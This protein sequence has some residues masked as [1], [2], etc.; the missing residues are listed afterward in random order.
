MVT[1]FGKRPVTV[2]GCLQA[3]CETHWHCDDVYVIKQTLWRVGVKTR[4]L[5]RPV[6]NIEVDTEAWCELG[7][8]ALSGCNNVYGT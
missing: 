5:M 6:S 1:A 2:W 8:E 3:A 7:G 4:G